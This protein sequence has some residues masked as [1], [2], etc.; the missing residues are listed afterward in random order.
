MTDIRLE[1]TE[2]G[3]DLALNGF[4]LDRDDGLESAVV[5]SLF[6]DARC[7]P[8]QIPD[9]DGNPRGYWGDSYATEDGD[10]TG[11]LLWLLKRE[12]RVNRVLNQARDYCQQALAWMVADQIASRVDVNTEYLESGVMMI[13]ANIYRPTG[14]SVAFQFDYAWD[15]QALRSSSST[16]ISV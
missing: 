11:S 8:E 6:T 9:K 1:I 5:M 12:K 15:Q 3:G 7:L 14:D 10:N 2:S 13:R 16:I 4:D